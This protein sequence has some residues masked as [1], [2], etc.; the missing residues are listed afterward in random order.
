M[1]CMMMNS[2]TKDENYTMQLEGKIRLA[3]V[4]RRRN[5]S[6]LVFTGGIHSVEVQYQVYDH[7]NDHQYALGRP[8]QL[9]SSQDIAQNVIAR[10][11]YALFLKQNDLGKDSN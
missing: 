6:N 11:K 7:A 1:T 4:G 2:G 10:G 9:H 8:T 5:R 3:S